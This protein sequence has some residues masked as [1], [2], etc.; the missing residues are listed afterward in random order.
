M[1]I[2]IELLLKIRIDNCYL[3]CKMAPPNC[4]NIIKVER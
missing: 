4:K 1:Q 2:I 3:V